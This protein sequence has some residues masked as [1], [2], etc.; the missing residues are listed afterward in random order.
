PFAWCRRLGPSP[1]TPAMGGKVPRPSLGPPFPRVLTPAGT[2]FKAITE[3]LSGGARPVYDEG[4]VG[5][6]GGDFAFNFGSAVAGPGRENV[7]T[8]YPFVGGPAL[9]PAQQHFNTTIPHVPVSS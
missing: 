1:T 9:S 8:G 2:L 6:N 4:F 7:G 5:P 3:T